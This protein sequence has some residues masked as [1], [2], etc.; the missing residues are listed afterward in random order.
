VLV[1]YVVILAGG[2]FGV[3]YGLTNA[4]GVV[5]DKSVDFQKATEEISSINRIENTT[6][7]NP[8]SK[9]EIEAIKNKNYCGIDAV[10]AFAPANA[11]RIIAS[12]SKTGSDALAAKMVLA[13]SLRLQVNPDFQSSL[14]KCQ[15]PN[16]DIQPT[17]ADLQEKY[18][19]SSGKNIF[20]WMN[21]SEWQT[22]ETATLK[23]KEA[24]NKAG[25]VADV[26]PRLIVASMIVEQLRLFNSEREVFKKFFEPLKILGNADK[27]SLGVMGIKEATAIQIENHLKD[28][29]SP[30]YLGPQDEHLLDF[31][32]DNPDQERFKRL[33]DEKN[34]HYY[35]YLYGALYLKEMM[36]QWQ[37]AGFDIQYRTE[38]VGTL[39]N[40]GFPQSKP[41]ADPKVGGSAIDVGD[42]KYSFGSLAYEFYYSGVM[43]DDF[44]YIIK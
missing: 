41:K 5:D 37:R 3:K 38:I 21:T 20:P 27:I 42:G 12:Y 39:F 18:G 36:E 6:S 8:D 17:L 40:V 11:G 26:E 19:N 31:S 32:T 1:I 44:P 4:A 9:N 23:D 33:T 22:I 25:A 28:P 16:N 10:G 35:S 14:F 2:F 24:I 43:T 30:Y 13:A 34:N 15:S 7:V 29:N